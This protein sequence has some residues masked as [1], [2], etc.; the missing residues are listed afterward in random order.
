MSCFE[1]NTYIRFHAKVQDNYSK[2]LG[3]II[4][5]TESIKLNGRTFITE[6]NEVHIRINTN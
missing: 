4:L 3:K 2:K 1:K 5:H 6:F